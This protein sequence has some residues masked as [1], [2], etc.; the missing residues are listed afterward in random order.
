MYGTMNSPPPKPPKGPGLLAGKNKTILYAVVALVIIAVIGM[1]VY[2]MLNKGGTAEPGTTPTL[3]VTTVPIHIGT[4]VIPVTTAQSIPATGTYV[5]VGYLGGFKGSYGMPDAMT[6]VPGNSGDRM[7]EVELANG[8][9]NATFEKLDGSTHELL[10]EIFRNGALLSQGRT[11]IGHGSVALSVNVTTGEALAPVTS[12]GS[13]T[14]PAAQNQTAP[15]ATTATSAV[16]ATPAVNGTTVIAT[17]AVTN[18][19]TA[20]TTAAVNTTATT[21]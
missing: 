1:V 11:T 20:A 15:A 6:I 8:T 13:T 4:V 18:V 17:T 9:V 10:V 19:A 3:P 21:P 16:T 2:P 14:T 7:W 12:G 5:H